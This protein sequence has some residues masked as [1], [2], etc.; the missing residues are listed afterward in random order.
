M[1][2]WQMTVRNVREFWNSQDFDLKLKDYEG[3]CEICWKKS[4]RKILTI[5]KDR[6]K[7]TD[8]WKE[9]EAKYSMLQLDSRE[10]HAEPVH[11]NRKNMS[12]QEIEA[13][14]H[15]DF[16]PATDVFWQ[17]N[18]EMDDEQAC[19]CMNDQRLLELEY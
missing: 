11:F 3:N 7:I 19:Q 13:L 12:I 5:V 16:V 10:H 9:M 17:Y 15:S 14:S 18:A 4:L 1:I 2:D 6:P 8:W